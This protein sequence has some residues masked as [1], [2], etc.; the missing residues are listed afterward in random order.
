MLYDAQKMELYV[1]DDD[2]VRRP[3]RLRSGGEGINTAHGPG[4][5][6]FPSEVFPVFP[7]PSKESCV[8]HITISHAE[9]AW[10]NAS[11]GI[12]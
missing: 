9:E 6:V 8:S 12:T 3:R 5:P 4:F 7:C 1:S 11:Q 2:T 10:F